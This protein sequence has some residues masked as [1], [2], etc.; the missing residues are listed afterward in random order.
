MVT[1]HKPDGSRNWHLI[2]Y[3]K[4]PGARSTKRIYVT[5]APGIGR[6]ETEAE[7]QKVQ[8]RIIAQAQQRP[9]PE[10]LIDY[11]KRDQPENR[12]VFR[13]NAEVLPFIRQR[14]ARGKITKGRLEAFERME[15]CGYLEFFRDVSIFALD[16]PMGERWLL[17]LEDTFPKMVPVSHR[18]II[19]DFWTGLRILKKLGVL[20]VVEKPPVVEMPE[21]ERKA[22]KRADALRIIEAMAE[23]RRGLFL[24]RTLA[25]LRVTESTRLN[26]CH[27]RDG[28]IHI[29]AS[30]AKTR[31]GRALLVAS[32]A[33][34]LDAWICKWRA[35]AGP[36]EPLFP[37]PTA[38]NADKR[39]LYNAEWNCWDRA[40]KQAGFEH[41]RPNWGGRH[42]FATHEVK[43]GTNIYGV[44]K[45]LGHKRF[46]TTQVY[47]ADFDEVELAEVM[48]PRK[49]KPEE[50]TR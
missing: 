17:W 24:S 30:I 36:F 42:S 18:H 26:V 45:W 46:Q 44:Q 38:L 8:A 31:K 14:H 16:E 23:D 50:E 47:L 2:C 7:A 12:V 48:R 19:R 5:W 41:V 33:P 29:P 15:R 35:N 49:I 13:F 43:S 37:N 27:Y 32:V 21:S 3:V 11:M 39:W 4:Y 10:V 40:C 20:K 9:L 25:G 22:L 28:T 6:I 1:V 34:E